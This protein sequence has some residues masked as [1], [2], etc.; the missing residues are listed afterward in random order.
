MSSP[1]RARGH[2]ADWDPSFLSFSECPGGLELRHIFRQLGLDFPQAVG[3]DQLSHPRRSED[4][5]FA[6]ACT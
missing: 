5:R 6:A 4:L 1:A 2:K 3:V